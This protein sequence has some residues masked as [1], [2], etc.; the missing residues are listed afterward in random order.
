MKILLKFNK[1]LSKWTI[2][3]DKKVLLDF[4]LNKNIYNN[5]SIFLKSYNILLKILRQFGVLKA[6]KNKK[7]Y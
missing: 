7:Q 4:S 2:F 1:E 3:I 6:L 5:Y